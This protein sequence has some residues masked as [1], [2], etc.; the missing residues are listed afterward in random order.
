[1]IGRLLGWN[2]IIHFRGLLPLIEFCQ[3]QNSP[4]VQVLRF[5]VLAALLH[6]TGAVGVCQ[7][8]R[9]GTRNG[10]ISSVIRGVLLHK[11]LIGPQ[12]SRDLQATPLGPR[13]L[14]RVR[15][16]VRACPP[17]RPRPLLKVR[18]TATA[19]VRLRL[20]VSYHVT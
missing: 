1:M 11:F 6:G 7:T 8:L 9:H 2:T 16:R 4:C 18:A 3:V 5:P 14:L 19:R 10:I 12:L 20:R 13:P 15:I 17:L